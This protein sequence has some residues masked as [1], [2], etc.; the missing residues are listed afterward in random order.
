MRKTF[1]V[2]V[3]VASFQSG[4]WLSPLLSASPQLETVGD[5]PVRLD[6]GQRISVSGLSNTTCEVI[7][8]GPRWVE[9]QSSTYVNL[10]TGVSFRITQ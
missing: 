8:Q 10:D 3:A 6:K 1:V 9:C 5:V 4:A 2:A 7:R